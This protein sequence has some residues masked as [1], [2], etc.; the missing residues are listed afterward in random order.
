MARDHI[1]IGTLPLDRKMGSIEMP[2]GMYA[3]TDLRTQRMSVVVNIR[4]IVKHAPVEVV[5]E[6]LDREELWEYLKNALGD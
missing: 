1:V 4:E 5:L 3:D 2:H 6:A